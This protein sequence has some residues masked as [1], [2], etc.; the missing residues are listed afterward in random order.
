MALYRG[1][2]VYPQVAHF[3]TTQAPSFPVAGD[4]WYDVSSK[5]LLANINGTVVSLGGGAIASVNLTG[6]TGTIGSTTL[7]AVPSN[8]A[9][10]YQVFADVI[11]TTAGTGGTVAVNVSWNNGTTT[12][13]LNS[14][15]FPLT[16]QG[17]QAALLGNF[18]STGSQNITYSTSVVG[19]TGS[20]IYTLRLIYLG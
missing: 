3:Q 7:F 19:A 14:A 17:E 15:A 6:Q 16:S 8:G 18:Y 9:G 1:E 13:G 11:V 2:H 5:T 10:I 20:P 12:A 4:V